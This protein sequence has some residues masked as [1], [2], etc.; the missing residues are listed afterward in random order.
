SMI[1]AEDGNQA[2]ELDDLILWL[3]TQ[4]APDVI[5]LSNALLAG[6]ARPL[7]AQLQRPVACLL[8]G[9]HTFLDDLP[10]SVRDTVWQTLAERCAD[11]DLFLPPSRYYADLMSRRLALPPERL[12]LLP[13]GINLAGYRKSQISDLQSH[14]PG[15]P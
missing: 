5:C 1:R 13:D 4:P 2:R 6:F 11:V 15:P 8:G 12:R 10:A 3:K 9:E 7:K 14:I